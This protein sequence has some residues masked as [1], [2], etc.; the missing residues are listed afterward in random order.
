[1]S[2][3][4]SQSSSILQMA[5]LH[6]EAFPDSANHTAETVEIKR[7]DDALIG[8]SLQP[9]ILIKI[10]V[11]GYE[12]KVI[13]G[14]EQLIDKTKA[15]I[16]EVSFRELYE[17]QPLFDRVFELLSRKHFQ[18][19]GNLYQLLNPKDGA[20]LHADALFVRS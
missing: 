14:G 1:M 11:Q 16:V 9:E 2:C 18:Y 10:D 13:A 12:D 6:K 3:A 19:M 4:Y 20:P 8:F 15:I 5:T 17:G 7:L